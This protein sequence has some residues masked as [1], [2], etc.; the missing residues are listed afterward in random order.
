[1]SCIVDDAPVE[2]VRLPVASARGWVRMALALGP[3]IALVALLG[4]VFLLPRVDV[5]SNLGYEMLNLGESLARDGTFSNPMA[6][7]ET[8]PTA[9][10]PPLYPLLLALYIKVFRDV[11]LVLLAAGVVSIF[12]N[13]V[14][15]V[16]LHSLVR[17][18]L[19]GTVAT[20][21]AVLWLASAWLGSSVDWVFWDAGI[22]PLLLIG[23]CYA[24]LNDSWSGRVLAGTLL[25]ELFLIN[26]AALVVAAA[27]WICTR[28]PLR[29]SLAMFAMAAVIGAPWVIRNYGLWGRFIVRENFGFTFYFSNN[30]CA[31]P[32]LAQNFHNCNSIR[33]PNGNP[34]EAALM[35]RIGE[36]AYDRLKTATAWDWIRANPGRFANL[37][38]M[39]FWFFWFPLPVEYR[40]QSYAT[41]FVT[42]LS[43]PGL[44]WIWRD[45]AP[46]AAFVSAAAVLYPAVYYLVVADIRYRAPFAW[47]AV[48]PA[49][50]A[51]DRIYRGV[52]HRH[53]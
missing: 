51:C 45:R 52:K 34:D 24:T 27:W 18:L 31:Q 53:G 46:W 5:K 9:T 33:H 43:I 19:G 25:G 16:L 38:A 21:A 35:R 44:L 36:P 1:M 30:P 11:D 49:A 8:G 32:H 40:F 26:P 6:S 2:T 29:R 42:L 28:I 37:T 10:E 17:R 7:L 14:A 3:L 41:W 23:F 39:R 20:F 4:G 13:A 47:V 50:Y 48:I 15:A 12:A 22:T